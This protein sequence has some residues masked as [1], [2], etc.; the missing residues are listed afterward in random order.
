MVRLHPPDLALL[1]AWAAEQSDNPSRPQALYRLA[2]I[3]FE[4]EAKRKEREV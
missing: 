4:T 1:D 3:G 2:Q